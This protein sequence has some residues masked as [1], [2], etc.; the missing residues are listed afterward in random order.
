MNKDTLDGGKE[1][2]SEIENE[3]LPMLSFSPVV[4]RFRFEENNE[5]HFLHNISC[6]SHPLVCTLA[7]YETYKFEEDNR[8]DDVQSAVLESFSFVEDAKMS[9]LDELCI[10][11][12]VE[13]CFEKY[14][15]KS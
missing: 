11:E 3:D 5:D 15:F 14:H 9:I 6:E 10:D 7:E 4:E 13:T 8:K 1:M 2:V 12:N